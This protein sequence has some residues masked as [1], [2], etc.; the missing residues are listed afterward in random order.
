MWNYETFVIEYFCVTLWTSRYI[1]FMVRWKEFFHLW[2]M[3]NTPKNLR[4]DTFVLSQLQQTNF[5]LFSSISSKNWKVF[6]LLNFF[7]KE[8]RKL[9]VSCLI[10]GV[11]WKYF[12]LKKLFNHCKFIT[13]TLTPMPDISSEVYTSLIGYKFPDHW[14]E[15]RARNANVLEGVEWEAK[16]PINLSDSSCLRWIGIWNVLVRRWSRK[17]I[18]LL[19]RQWEN[20]FEKNFN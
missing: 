4:L 20:Y 19:R 10:C 7:K 15:K 8:A 16:C 3:Y 6:L 5:F 11:S 9:F 1:K 13:Y 2:C 14:T 17:I 18:G 12:W